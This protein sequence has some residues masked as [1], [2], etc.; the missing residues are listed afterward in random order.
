MIAFMW[1][2]KVGIYLHA[3]MPVKIK[4]HGRKAKSI[5]KYGLN[6]IAQVLLNAQNK[7]DIDICNFFVMCL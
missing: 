4:A 2:Y 3:I 5:F 1:C 6:H 7:D